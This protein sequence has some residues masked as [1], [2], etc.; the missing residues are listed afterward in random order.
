MLSWYGGM[1]VISAADYYAA[2]LPETAA[3]PPA[4]VKQ[5]GQQ[6]QRQQLHPK[7][8]PMLQLQ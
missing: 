4:A 1:A 2:N 6:Q 8:R 7:M 5:A 3:V